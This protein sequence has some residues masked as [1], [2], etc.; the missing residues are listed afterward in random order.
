MEETIAN[1][2]AEVLKGHEKL[3]AKAIVVQLR[4]ETSESSVRS[5]LSRM[6]GR[7]QVS[8]PKYGH[9][10]LTEKG[11]KELLSEKHTLELVKSA[12]RG[13]KN[14]KDGTSLARNEDVTG[15]FKPKLYIMHKANGK[16]ELEQ[17]EESSPV[18][19]DAGYAREHISD[20]LDRVITYRIAGRTGQQRYT[21][22]TLLFIEMTGGQL[23]GAGDYLVRVAGMPDIYNLRGLPDGSVRFKDYAEG[24]EF[25]VGQTSGEVDSEHVQIYG[26]VAMAMVRY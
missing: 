20:E 15:L 9:Y 14:E 18:A 2:I 19:F 13:E 8:K 16:Y 6:K 25:V 1:D 24:D 3:K 5:E 23:A 7:G 17:A 11:T 4:G 22:D 26:R 12:S 21:K 10:A